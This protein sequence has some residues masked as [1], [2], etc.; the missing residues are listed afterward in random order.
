MLSLLALDGKRAVLATA[1]RVKILPATKRGSNWD[2]E[3][4]WISPIEP[5]DSVAVSPD[6]PESGRFPLC[7]RLPMLVPAPMRTAASWTF[8]KTFTVP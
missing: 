7:P 1:F 8:T 6:G 5:D 4:L 3:R 2:A